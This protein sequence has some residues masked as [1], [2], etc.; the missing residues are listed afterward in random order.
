[1]TRLLN[2]AQLEF[3]GILLY[4]TEVKI[5]SVEGF[6]SRQINALGFTDGRMIQISSSDL[7][8]KQLAFVLAHEVWHIL[9]FHPS[10]CGFRDPK[11]WNLCVDHVTNRALMHYVS[12]GELEIPHEVVI[13]EDI[14]SEDPE[15]SA[16]DLYLKLME[17][18]N[19]LKIEVFKIGRDGNPTK[20]PQEEND[21]NCASN[22]KKQNDKSSKNKDT[23][24]ESDP[25]QSKSN[26]TGNSNSGGLEGKRFAKVTDT[27]TK[28]QWVVPLDCDEDYEK[29]KEIE[30]YCKKLSDKGKFLWNSNTIQKGNMPGELVSELDQMF[31]VQIPWDEILNTAIMY[32]AQN[33]QSR[34]WQ[35]RDYY[36]RAATLPGPHQSQQTEIAMFFIDTSGS[37]S[38]DDLKK[39]VGICCDSALHFDKIGII[40]HDSQLKEPFHWFEN[41]PDQETIYK[42]IKK[43]MGR[44]GTSHE[45]CF[46]LVKKLHETE[47]I[48]VITFLTDYYSDV[49]HI[50]KQYEWFK[51]LP[52]IWV[53]NSNATPSFED[54]YTFKH[55][56][57]N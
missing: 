26:N 52:T 51:D 46:N 1:M 44:G 47:L 35:N 4:G 18:K 14:H 38:N 29:Q 28:K 34:S 30:K 57:I 32:Y 11:V 10:R 54:E 27:K 43:I 42:K 20:E 40:M 39:F 56:R 19:R 55:I 50:Y 23:S 3:L 6:V 22:N 37:V 12:R 15:I 21:S 36:I 17:D 13:F 48:S 41:R 33:M 16:E 2:K 7:T 49:E 25:N 45:G 9:S 53:L 31:H 5:E 24:E 8:P